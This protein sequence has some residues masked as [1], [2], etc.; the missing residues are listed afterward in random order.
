MFQRCHFHLASR[1]VDPNQFV[2]LDESWAKLNMTRLYGWAP[3]GQRCQDQIAHGHWQTLTMLSAI[4]RSGVLAEA[5]VLIDGS[6]NAVTFE[7]YVEHCLAPALKPGD[8]VV[9]D[10]LSS[11]KTSKV[12]ESI[13]A[14]EA[15][16]WYL[17]P[18]SPDLNPIESMWSK[19]KTFLRRSMART[20]DQLS[21]AMASVL[22]SVTADEC[23][24][25]FANCGYGEKIGKMV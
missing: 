16:L 5:T 21:E 20:V 24:N 12:A 22:R 9:M 7:D 2:F 8:V 14:V 3:K 4:R 13:E 25:Y 11:H 15:N 18:Y 6:I 19:V 1:F 23:C 10:N 17:P